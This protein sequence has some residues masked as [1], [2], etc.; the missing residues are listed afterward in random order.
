M[1]Q[2]CQFDLQFAFARAGALGEDIQNQRGAI[3]DLAVENLFKVPAL[4]WG[5][6]VVKDY[7]IDIGFPAMLGKFVSFAF[8]NKSAGARRGQFLDAIPNDGSSGGRGQFGKFFQGIVGFPA[9]AG[10]KFY[11]DKKD[12]FSPSVPRLD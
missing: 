4:G 6:F 3:E 12:P 10:F 1:L 9:V 2:L 5:Q 11:T 8:A 7:R